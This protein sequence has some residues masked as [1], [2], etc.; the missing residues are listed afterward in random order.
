VNSDANAWN[1][2]RI[3]VSLGAMTFRRSS[4]PIQI[5]PLI[6]PARAPRGG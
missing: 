2:V 3:R 1:S 4:G 5:C 6:Q